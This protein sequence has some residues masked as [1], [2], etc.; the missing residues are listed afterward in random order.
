MKKNEQKNLHSLQSINRELFKEYFNF[1]EPTFMLKT[2]YNTPTKKK[3][4]KL[5][6]VI[7]SA[8]SDLKEQKIE[9]ISEE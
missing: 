3:N 9:G 2:L 5:V 4:N 8:L 7:K 1:Q 6:S